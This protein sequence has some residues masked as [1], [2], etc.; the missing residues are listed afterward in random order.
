MKAK[1]IM[2]TE[3]EYINITKKQY[4]KTSARFISKKNMIISI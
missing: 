4:S 3:A 2:K 1:Q